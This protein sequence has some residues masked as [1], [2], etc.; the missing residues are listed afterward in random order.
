MPESIAPEVCDAFEAR[1]IAVSAFFVE[2]ARAWRIDAY[3]A[4]ARD[5]AALRADLDVLR[6]AGSIGTDPEVEIVPDTDWLAET[7]R[8]FPPFD[9]GRFFVC[10]S[11]AARPVPAG[12]IPLTIN[13]ATAF[14]S[15]EHETTRGCLEALLRL[16]AEGVRA[17]NV[18]DLGTGSGIL[19]IAA[20]KIFGAAVLAVDSD[21]AAIAEA[22][23]NAGRNGVGDR[24]TA[25]SSIGY[26]AVIVGR[27]APFD[28]VFANILAGPLVL[29]AP[30]LARHLAAGRGV[31]VL[32]G[33]LD[34]QAAVVLA[35]HDRVGLALRFAIDHGP[36]RTLVLGWA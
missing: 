35:A 7:R 16:D 25:A 12:R 9:V 8:A 23:A 1:G 13:A 14:G 20:A 4:D 31:A 36:W 10:G 24:V 15:G 34:E 21:P 17:S 26:D 33:L 5:L 19:A 28:L 3:V 6:I 30:D 18:L 11:H 32:S 22:E 27:R 2:A 29:L